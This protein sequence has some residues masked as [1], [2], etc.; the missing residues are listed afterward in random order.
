MVNGDILIISH[1]SR[2]MSYEVGLSIGANLIHMSNENFC[3]KIEWVIL[4]WLLMTDFYTS[5][6]C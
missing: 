5:S 6:C 2:A 4:V 3:G 1:T